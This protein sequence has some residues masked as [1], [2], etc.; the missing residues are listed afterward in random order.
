M[1]KLTLVQPYQLTW[2]SLSS[3]MWILSVFSLGE[4]RGKNQ[5]LFFKY[6]PKIP[7]SAIRG[8]IALLQRQFLPPIFFWQSSAAAGRWATLRATYAAHHLQHSDLHFTHR[9]PSR[10]LKSFSIGDETGNEQ[11]FQYQRQ[12]IISVDHYFLA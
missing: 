10:N 1:Q 11:G 5:Y 7:Q 3:T 9:S 6:A 4:V 12:T 2:H 8:I